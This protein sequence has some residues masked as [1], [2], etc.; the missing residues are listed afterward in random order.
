[1]GNNSEPVAESQ[2]EQSNFLGCAADIVSAYVGQNQI[3][4]A[5]LPTLIKSIYGA[6]S[7]LSKPEPSIDPPAALKP[8]VSIRKSI[9]DD[10]LICLEDGAKLKVLKRYLRS[11]YNMSPSDYRTRWGLPSDY[12]MVAPNYAKAR[13]EAAKR[14]WQDRLSP[15][16]QRG[17]KRKAG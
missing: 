14:I 1:M 15:A 5:D 2:R 9:T 11:Y 16:A 4:L 10:Y 6:L 7:G 17:R 13:S 3:P 12:P 8:A